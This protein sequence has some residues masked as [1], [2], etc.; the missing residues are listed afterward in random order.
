MNKSL[1]LNAFL[2][3][4]LAQ[5]AGGCANSTFEQTRNVPSTFETA[6]IKQGEPKPTNL[7]ITLSLG[8]DGVV[9]G[10]AGLEATQVL[11]EEKTEHAVLMKRT[12]SNGNWADH[13]L[14]VLLAPVLV[15]IALAGDCGEECWA[16]SATKWSKKSTTEISRVPTGHVENEIEKGGYRG[17][18]KVSY[19][20]FVKGKRQRT[21]DTIYTSNGRFEILIAKR[22]AA[23]KRLPSKMII[24]ATVAA[25]ALTRKARVTLTGHQIQ[26][27][28]SREKELG[29]ERA[30]AAQEQKIKDQILEA[31]EK[32]EEEK[33]QQKEA[34]ERAR[35]QLRQQQQRAERNEIERRGRQELM[36][37]IKKAGEDIVETNRRAHEQNM[38][39]QRQYRT[40]L[41]EREQA[42]REQSRR[43]VEKQQRALQ[44][45]NEARQKKL[46][47]QQKES[48]QHLAQLQKKRE[49]QR[50]AL[51][52]QLAN[53]LKT[54]SYTTPKNAVGIIATTPTV[55]IASEKVTPQ[56]TPKK[57]RKKHW[58]PEAVAICWQNKTKFWFCDG[59]VQQTFAGEK[60]FAKS[61][62]YAGCKTIRKSQPFRNVGKA[63]NG[64]V[65][66]F[67]DYGAGDKAGPSSSRDIAHK[68]GFS[69]EI[70]DT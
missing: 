42:N 39:I 53:N 51:K 40:R 45:K 13:S 26:K 52:K 55:K 34:F 58:I 50:I 64:T 46:A 54:V 29:I 22:V 25:D 60:R 49:Q 70:A 35:Y 65:L 16:V 68:Y 27:I 41:A 66:L 7:D 4:L 62:K 28:V 44:Q 9:S 3:T 57:P 20:L 2:M 48:R 12:V 18:I 14:K 5:L 59:P 37:S 15:P 43:L 10:Y 1:V 33:E 56:P 63:K 30:L 23:L 24:V 32:A 47:R 67:C 6:L 21:T 38:A 17:S 19:D 11:V 69:L 8:R 31:E 61:A 36:A